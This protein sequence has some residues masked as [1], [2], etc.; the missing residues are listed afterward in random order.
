MRGT[1]FPEEVC[2]IFFLRSFALLI[3]ESGAKIPKGGMESL[4]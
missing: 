4:S 3:F 1:A 2:A